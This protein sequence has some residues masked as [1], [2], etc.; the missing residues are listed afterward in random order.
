MIDHNHHRF[1]FVVTTRPDSHET[2]EECMDHLPM[3]FETEQEASSGYCSAMNQLMHFESEDP[4]DQPQTVKP[5]D[6]EEIT[7]DTNRLVYRDAT[8]GNVVKILKVR[9]LPQT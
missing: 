8:F 7:R 1:V 9:I 5:E 3:A 4:E 6:L 2:D